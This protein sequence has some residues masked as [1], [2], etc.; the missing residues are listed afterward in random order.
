MGREKSDSTGTLESCPG[1]HRRNTCSVDLMWWTEL[2]KVF[3]TVSFGFIF[4]SFFG[5]AFSCLC[6]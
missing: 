2:V 3:Q 1:P 4:F 6:C 5:M